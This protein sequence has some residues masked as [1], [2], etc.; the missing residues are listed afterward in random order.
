MGASSDR[1]NGLHG[2]GRLRLG[3]VIE[4]ST[5]RI[6]VES[7]R[8]H[9]L[10]PLG[11]VVGTSS[12]RGH[13]IYAIVSYAQTAGID[14]TR[15]AIRRGSAEVRDEEVYRRHP[16]LAHLLRSSFEAIPVAYRE[17]A[18]A[19]VRYLLPPLPPALHYTVETVDE[20]EL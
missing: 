10:P 13:R 16:E 2:A 5:V 8:L 17:S 19:G 18:A 7:D 1:S 9:E 4:T 6:W 20:G 11:A 12:Q 3:E 14:E 15:R